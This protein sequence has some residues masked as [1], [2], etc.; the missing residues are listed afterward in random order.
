MFQGN[1]FGV[2]AGPGQCRTHTDDLAIEHN[3]GPDRRTRRNAT[4]CLFGQFKCSVERVNTQ[5]KS[6]DL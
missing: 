1:R 2:L 6:A 4:L 3:Y 5:G